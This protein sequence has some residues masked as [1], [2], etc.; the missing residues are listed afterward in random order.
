MSFETAKRRIHEARLV[1]GIYA[2][3][4]ALAIM[5]RHDWRSRVFAKHILRAAVEVRS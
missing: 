2:L 4:W 1:L 5:P 3:N